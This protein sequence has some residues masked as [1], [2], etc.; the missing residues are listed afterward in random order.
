MLSFLLLV[1]RTMLDHW[2]LLYRRG[3]GK[4]FLCPFAC[5]GL[6]IRDSPL[7]SACNN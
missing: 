3:R 2:L 4:G 1:P 6:R 5:H 7:E